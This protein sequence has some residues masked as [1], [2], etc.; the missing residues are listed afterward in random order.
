MT[1]SKKHIGYKI[2][3]LL[4]IACLILPLSIK[5]SHVFSHHE[6]EVCIAKDQ[7]HFHEIDLDCDFYKFKI[8]QNLFFEFINYDL[9][10]TLENNTSIITY[11][12]YLKSNQ[13]LTSFLRGPPY[14]V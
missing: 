8:N 4:V 13:Q 9:K 5:L 10:S 6:H 14:L 1:Y 3:S 11:Y 2:A 12:T 7:S